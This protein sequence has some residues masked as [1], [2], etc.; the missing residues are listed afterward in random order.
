[1]YT[2]IN[3]IQSED[4][5]WVLLDFKRGSCGPFFCKRVIRDLSSKYSCAEVSDCIDMAIFLMVS[6]HGRIEKRSYAMT[7]NITEPDI[8]DFVELS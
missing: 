7:L 6:D 8:H 1:M 4:G 3:W 5:I 2:L